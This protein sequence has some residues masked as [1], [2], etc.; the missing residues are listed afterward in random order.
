M[1]A[2]FVQLYRKS[3]QY[4]LIIRDCAAWIVK[5]KRRLTCTGFVF[6]FRISLFFPGFIFVSWW[7]HQMETF[8]ALLALCAGNSPVPD[9]FP[10][11]RP[12]T[13]T[14]DVFFDLRL[15]KRL[16]KQWWGWW[17]ETPSRPL[18]RHCNAIF[19]LNNP[20]M[21]YITRVSQITDNLTVFF[22]MWYLDKQQG[23]H[24]M[25]ALLAFCKGVHLKKF[26]QSISPTASN[27]ESMIHVITSSRGLLLLTWFNFNLN[28]D[29]WS[30]AQ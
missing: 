29:K 17:L 20:A 27:A 23:H 24:Q 8:S 12:V 4:G 16:S 25:L 30:H 28:M 10:T 19:V 22:S 15:N 9:E 5:F 3:F 6:C 21:Q 11:Q 14:F 18:W 26:Q 1:H 2:W 7:R 13:R